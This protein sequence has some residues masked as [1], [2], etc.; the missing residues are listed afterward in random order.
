MKCK[1]LLLGALSS[2]IVTV[3]SAQITLEA[4]YFQSMVGEQL[5]VTTYGI[6][7]MNGVDALV[8]TTGANVTY[9]FNTFS[10]GEGAI[11]ETFLR[12]PSS[13]L[14]GAL[15]PDLTDADYVA[16]SESNEPDFPGTAYGYYD[17]QSDGLFLLG[18]VVV[19]DFDSDGQNDIAAIK[20]SP[21]QRIFQFPL[22]MGTSWTTSYNRTVVLDGVAAFT[23]SVQENVVVDGWGL[24]I[25]PTG[26]GACLRLAK[27]KQETFL[28]ITTT[29]TTYDFITQ[30][31]LSA[32]IIV[33]EAGVVIAAGYEV[34]Q[35][36]APSASEAADELP[37]RI[38]LLQN[39]PNPFNPSTGIPFLLPQPSPVTLRVYDVLG[40]HVDT[41]VDGVLPAG[42]HTVEWQPGTLP[43]GLY[44]YQLSADAVVLSRKM[45]LLR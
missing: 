41:L 35:R 2:V 28:T 24:L 32:D 37:E 23:S 21:P 12:A 22:T 30:G 26:E 31:E 40:K 8:N 25:T 7:D 33:D 45:V 4:S 38:R 18:L 39:Y 1:L 10:Y 20:S 44:I 34:L 43:N 19:G 3:A 17:F 27:T 42:A 9:P 11:S 16:I 15:D 14:P 13:D 29:T 6:N 5:T 36:D